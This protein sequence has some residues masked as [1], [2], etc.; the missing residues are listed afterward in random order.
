M[1][2]RKHLLHLLKSLRTKRE[3]N[4]LYMKCSDTLE[5]L[6]KKFREEA[7]DATLVEHVVSKIGVIA[8]PTNYNEALDKARQRVVK[9]ITNAINSISDDAC[10]SFFKINIKKAIHS[11]YTP[12][13]DFHHEWKV[14]T[15]D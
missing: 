6:V 8:R 2:Q 11:L 7:D 13:V 10:R 5:D 9:N 3:Y 4:S 15:D 12:P 1:A 14:F